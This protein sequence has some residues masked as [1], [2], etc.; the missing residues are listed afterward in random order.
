MRSS[1]TWL[2]LVPLLLLAFWLGARQIDAHPLWG[3]EIRTIAD[4]RGDRNHPWTIPQIWE[5]VGKNNP[6]HAPGY[7]FLMRIL[8]PLVNWVPAVMRVYPLLLG[9]L[10]IAWT[11][12]LGRDW[13]SPSIGLIAAMLMTT[14]A[15]FVR[16]LYEL[17]VYSLLA[18]VSA[19]SLW[20]YIRI[21]TSPKPPRL[22]M[23]AALF[24]VTAIAFYS[25]YLATVPLI[26]IGLYH[27][28]FVPKNR[29]WWQVTVAVVTGSLTFLPWIPNLLSGVNY[30]ENQDTNGLNWLST[31]W[32]F[33]YMFSNGPVVVSIL[34]V[35]SA[36]I[37]LRHS[38][39][40]QSYGQL[41]FIALISLI[42]ILVINI[43]VGIINLGGARYFIS[44][45]PLFALVIAAGIMQ[46][47]RWP[48][49]V[50]VVV[51]FCVS[52]GLYATLFADFT[53]NLAGSKALFPIQHVAAV[54][55]QSRGQNGDIVV[56]YLPNSNRVT[57]NFTYTGIAGLYYG[58]IHTAAVM[59]MGTTRPRN[60]ESLVTKIKTYGRVWIAYLPNDKPPSLAVLI[61]D[62]AGEFHHCGTLTERPDATIDLYA[63]NDIAC[64]NND[65]L[66]L[67]GR[68]P[69]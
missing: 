25:H 35:G 8:G 42:L 38:K 2:W 21:I 56:H 12:R 22:R 14:S 33:F 55:Q 45:W 67:D 39:R 57:D 46:L 64:P 29:R 54:L 7:F 65:A 52:S 24:A 44:L 50:I 49:V 23:L 30:A 11:Y 43:V 13:L 40:R 27:L 37:G 66:Y 34:L 69:P 32:Y 3:D 60:E 28:L 36:F 20:I 18:L 59:A 9:I 5:N 17:R 68:Q 51:L 10:A 31:L 19:L 53:I 6:W 58:S 63:R 61:S 26:A 4:S 47:Q 62:I 41:L 16:Y 1:K 15:F 48:R